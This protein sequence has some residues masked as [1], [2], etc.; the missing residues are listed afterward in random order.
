MYLVRHWSAHREAVIRCGGGQIPIAVQ[1]KVGS[2][3]NRQADAGGIGP[4]RS[5]QVASTAVP[6]PANDRSIPGY[7]LR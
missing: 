2:S 4:G 6:V 1:V 3:P 7:M 5:T